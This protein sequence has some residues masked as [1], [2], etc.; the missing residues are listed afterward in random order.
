MTTKQLAFAVTKFWLF[1]FDCEID[2]CVLA[3]IFSDC[4]IAISTFISD[5]IQIHVGGMT[6][7]SSVNLT[8]KLQPLAC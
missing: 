1:C 6:I 2:F 3:E 4:K 7:S 8:M 5:I